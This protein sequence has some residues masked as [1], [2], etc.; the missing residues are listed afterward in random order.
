MQIQHKNIILTGAAS[1]IGKALLLQL[2]DFE[3]IKIIAVDL[4]KVDIIS[5]KVIPY[6]CDVSKQ[7]EIDQLFEF[8]LAH[9]QT[10]DIFI[11][12]AGFAYYEE[13]GQPDWQRIEKIFQVNVFAPIYSFQKMKAMNIGREYFVVMTASAMAKV[14]IPGYALYGATKAALDRFEDAYRFES[15]DLGYLSLIYPIATKSNFFNRS[16]GF[17]RSDVPIPFPAHTPEEVAKA[18]IEGMQNNETHIFPSKL[19]QFGRFFQKLFEILAYPYQYF[20]AQKLK[21]WKN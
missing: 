19:F 1:G 18:M 2:L 20:Y 13:I 3:G 16:T 12:N 15:Q 7:V 8:A 11:A 5:E 17:S 21:K 10:I 6:F 9:F 14:A 4:N